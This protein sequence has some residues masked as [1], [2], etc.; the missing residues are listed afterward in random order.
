MIRLDGAGGRLDPS[1]GIELKKRGSRWSLCL[2][3]LI[4][5]AAKGV[6]SHRGATIGVDAE[7]G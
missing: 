7:G 2:M 6:E 1:I 4:F 3:I 5:E